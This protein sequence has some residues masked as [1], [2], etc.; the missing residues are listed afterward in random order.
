MRVGVVDVGTNS[1]RLL[2]ADVQGDRVGEVARRTESTQLGAGVDEPRKLLPL[3]IARV[4]NV[5]SGYRREL[6]DLG[7]E[8]VLAVGTS[9]IRDAENGEAFLG[10]VEWS[11]GF[12]TRLLSGEDEA[13]LTRRGVANGR[14]LGADTLVLDIGGRSTELIPTHERISLDLG[15]LRLTER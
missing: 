9:A 8:R 3:P 5:L 2:V 6:A 14:G 7:A 10:E 1:T 12:A 15:S 4:R 11:N 13:D